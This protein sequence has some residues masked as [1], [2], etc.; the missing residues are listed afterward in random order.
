MDWDRCRL[1]GQIKKILISM[2]RRGKG[3]FGRGWITI[4]KTDVGVGGYRRDRG[5]GWIEARCASRF[6]LERRRVLVRAGSMAVAMSGLDERG[7]ERRFAEDGRG[8]IGFGGAIGI[9]HETSF[10]GH[11]AL[12]AGC[13]GL[14]LAGGEAGR[15]FKIGE[16]R[17]GGGGKTK[18]R[19]SFSAGGGARRAAHS[20]LVRYELGVRARLR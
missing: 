12:L 11:A 16:V 7:M 17:I 6:A 13:A 10:L 4:G 1:V 5:T 2:G 14:G 15:T 19:N 8:D 9:G 20:K 3:R 18:V